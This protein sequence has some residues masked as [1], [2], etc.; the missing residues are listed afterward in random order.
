VCTGKKSGHPRGMPLVTRM[1]ASIEHAWDP[2]A[3]S[4]VNFC[5]KRAPYSNRSFAYPHWHLPTSCVHRR[6]FADSWIGSQK[7]VSTD[8]SAVNSST[9]F[10]W[11]YFVSN[12]CFGTSVRIRIACWLMGG[13]MVRLWSVNVLCA[14]RPP[15]TS[16][17]KSTC[18]SR[19][20]MWQWGRGA[21]GEG[22]QSAQMEMARG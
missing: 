4:S 20:S 9:T 15:H 2:M 3:F 17:L 5:R 8:T 18:S 22:E 1:F 13:S 21:R 16:G 14:S 12:S 11:K 6:H 19:C 10:G 7:V